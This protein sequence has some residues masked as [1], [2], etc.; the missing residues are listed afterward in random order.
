MAIDLKL[1]NETFQKKALPSWPC[2]RCDSG[3]LTL[4]EKQLKVFE[5]AYSAADHGHE[6]WEPDWMVERFIALMRCGDKVCGETVLVIGD[7]EFVEEFD[8]EYGP[9]PASHLRPRSIFPAPPIIT[10]PGETPAEV[11]RQIEL[12]FQLYWSDLSAASNR[13]RT[14]VERLLDDFKIAKGFTDPKTKKKLFRSLS[15]RIDLF[16]KKQPNHAESL[17]ALRYVGNV[18]THSEVS[19]QAILAAFE[20]YEEALAEIYGH[21]TRRIKKLVKTIRKTKG[22]MR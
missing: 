18:G 10:I 19:R 20:I 16:K 9:V 3:R 7:T 17:D 5:P 21:R 8:E 4:G 14:S 22:R 2:P 6:A 15:S 12:A 13:L 1:W 11:S